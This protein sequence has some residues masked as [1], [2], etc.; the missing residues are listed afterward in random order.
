MIH[1]VGISHR[2]TPVQRREKV[3]VAAQALPQMLERARR[4]LGASECVILSTCNR[5]EIY[6]VSR[7]TDDPRAAALELLVADARVRAAIPAHEVYARCGLEAATHLC[8]VTAGLD[9]LILGEHEILAQVKGAFQA[10]RDAGCAGRLLRRLW[11]H[12]L[13]A[14]KRARA[15][16]RIASGIFSVGHCAARAAAELFGDPSTD[17]GQALRGR[18]LLVIG[19]GRIAEATAKHLAHQGA[20][21]ITVANRTLEHAQAVAER[22]DGRADTIGNLPALLGAADL[23]ITCTAAPHFILDAEQV[24]RAM[25]GRAARPMVVIDVSVPRDVEPRAGAVAGV[26]LFNLDDL[27]PVV[28]ENAKAREGEVSA[29]RG[30]IAEEVQAFEDWRQRDD[31]VPLIRSLHR[32][33]DA[34]RRECLEQI[35]ARMSHLA[36]EDLEAVERLT[37]LLVKRLLHAPTAALRAHPNGSRFTM[38]AAVKELFALSADAAAQPEIT[39]DAGRSVTSTLDHSNTG[40]CDHVHLD[41]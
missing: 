33:G 34:V 32:R 37:G 22:L 15:E 3:A 12:A 14:G 41:S 39:T 30:I 25:A 38:S 8:E 13:R 18:S 24:R 36:P 6:F 10:A 16:T 23:V 29:V 28:A 1:V 11:D 9:S 2:R 5:T 21:P 27:E 19:A 31:I 4:C 20:A 7:R 35:Q 17:S 26:R 40:G